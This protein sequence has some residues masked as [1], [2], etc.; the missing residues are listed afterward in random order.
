MEN[1]FKA[2]IIITRRKGSRGIPFR[3]WVKCQPVSKGGFEKASEALDWAQAYVSNR[4]D[5]KA[6][7]NLTE[8][9]AE[10][11][12]ISQDSAIWEMDNRRM[13]A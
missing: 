3:T 13:D 6:V 8:T 7:V 11:R 9:N 5:I 2:S 12:I 1:T 4:K 10:G